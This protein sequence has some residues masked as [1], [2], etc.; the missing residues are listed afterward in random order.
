[1]TVGRVLSAMPCSW[2]KRSTG[3]VLCVACLV[4]GVLASVAAASFPGAN[5]RI[6]YSAGFDPNQSIHTI[7]PSG[8][9]D[10]VI[11]DRYGTE[12]SWSPTG[13]RIAFDDGGNISTMRADGSDERQLT[14]EHN[15]FPYFSS[16]YNPSYSPSGG[17]IAFEL[18]S[19]EPPSDIRTMRSD[20][21]D[22][23]V[24]FNGDSD[25][26]G[27]VWSPN[28]EIAYNGPG[29]IWAMNPDGS[30]QHRLVFGGTPIYSPNGS[31]F[32]FTRV[33]R[34]DSV[35]TK[36]A[37]ADGG[38]VREPPCA[39]SLDRMESLES[40]SPDGHWILAR[41]ANLDTAKYSLLR[42]SLRSCEAKRVVGG[43]IGPSADWQPLPS[44]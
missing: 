2:G 12:F 9:G 15:E 30:H 31:K 38:N 20:G 13:Q 6:V 8:Y 10:R 18:F 36:L 33:W 7:L 26:S 11:A 37:D 43:E 24:I 42:I 44:G 34:D 32:L 29:G 17:R 40:Y 28:R 35:H 23:H 39:G 4:S 14:F 22:L 1:M 19:H 3:F 16:A 25:P 41:N 27:A 21:S 5:G